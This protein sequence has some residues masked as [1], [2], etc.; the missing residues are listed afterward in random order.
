[1]LGP[2]HKFFK[3][4]DWRTCRLFH[5]EARQGSDPVGQGTWNLILRA[6]KV[7]IIDALAEH[8]MDQLTGTKWLES[9]SGDEAFKSLWRRIARI[10]P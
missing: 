6:P 7:R 5:C 10:D 9:Q 2:E 3:A 1:M 8:G 4:V